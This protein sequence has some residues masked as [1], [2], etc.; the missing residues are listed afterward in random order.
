MSNGNIIIF[1]EGLNEQFKQ[2]CDSVL[3]YM[4]KYKGQKEYIFRNFLEIFHQVFDGMDYLREQELVHRDVKG[5]CD[6]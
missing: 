1:I 3:A 5:M 6:F 2:G 4:A